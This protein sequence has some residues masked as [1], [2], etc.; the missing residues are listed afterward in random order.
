MVFLIGE[1][2]V[3]WN[4]DLDIARQLM[5]VA[6]QNNLNSVK[7]QSFSKEIVKD[8]PLS[9][10]LLESSISE[11]NIQQIDD[12]AKEIGI[13]WFATPM[14]PEAVSL[15]EPYVKRYK[16][17]EYDGRVLAKN[18][19]SKLID[20]ILET[21]KDV[22]ISSQALPSKLNSTGKVDWIYCVPKYPCSLGDLDFTKL[23][24]FKGFSNHCP[25]IIA[26]LC[27]SILG[28]KII[29][30]HMTLNKNGN[31][32]DN[33]VSFDPSDLQQLSNLISSSEKIK[34]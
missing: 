17:R 16:I 8:H 31:F 30:V 32:V 20:A 11:K 9:E 15:L 13:D 26:P 21:G 3:N 28:A 23:S 22:I 4:G 6:K 14:Y 18:S 2:G 27:A 29:E 34:K 24:F 10:T 1:I 25:H 12:L 7:F 19:T 33:N 5:V